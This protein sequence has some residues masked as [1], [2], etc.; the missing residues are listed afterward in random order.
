M[1]AQNLS[2]TSTIQ[3]VTDRWKY[4][5]FLGPDYN[6]GPNTG[7]NL[8]DLKRDHNFD[9]P[10]YGLDFSGSGFRGP[11]NRAPIIWGS[12]TGTRFG[13]PQKK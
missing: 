5:P 11:Y 10:P 4:P 9:N 6:T 12:R 8:G 1:R 13:K 2:D 3:I 7:S